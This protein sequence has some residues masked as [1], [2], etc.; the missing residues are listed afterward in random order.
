MCIV[1]P[2]E[3]TSLDVR[4]A[5]LFVPPD[6]ITIL[7]HL[8]FLLKSYS[9]IDLVYNNFI[10]LLYLQYTNGFKL[11]INISVYVFNFIMK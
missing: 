4:V 10:T 9:N 3:L 8:I 2:S 7:R 11:N 6:Q 5:R 1:A